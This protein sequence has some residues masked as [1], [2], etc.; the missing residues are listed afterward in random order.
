M[1]NYFL[2]AFLSCFVMSSTHANEFLDLGDKYAETGDW[3]MAINAYQQAANS[4]PESSIVHS[5]LGGAYL[6]TQGYSNSIPH[7]QRA[8]SLDGNNHGAFIGMG[9]AD[10]H[11]GR[12]KLSKAALMEAR[13]LATDKQEDI[14]KMIAWID[15]KTAAG[16]DMEAH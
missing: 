15:S 13:K 12:Y 16:S 1:R 3:E 7:F 9:I 14:D 5:R 8:I 2:A 6:T 11:M 10:L 4:Q